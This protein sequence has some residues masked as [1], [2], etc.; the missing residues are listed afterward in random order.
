M[1]VKVRILIREATENEK[2]IS[3]VFQRNGN[4]GSG[5]GKAVESLKGSSPG[6]EIAE[7]KIL[8]RIPDATE[9]RKW[10]ESL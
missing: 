8:N 6:S 5:F 4:G 2:N 3:G 10:V 7:G 1:H 9:L